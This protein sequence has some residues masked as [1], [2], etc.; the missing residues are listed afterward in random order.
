MLHRYPEAAQSDGRQTTTPEI[1]D[2]RQEQPRDGAL[3]AVIGGGLAGRRAVSAPCV[4]PYPAGSG[5]ATRSNRVRSRC[6]R[7]D[8]VG[9]ASD[10]RSERDG[11][12]WRPSVLDDRRQS[13]LSSQPAYPGWPA[14]VVLSRHTQCG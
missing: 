2:D 7:C 11:H 1:A 9:V 10:R 14:S 8:L 5:P 6:R 3:P 12:H 13:A 4:G